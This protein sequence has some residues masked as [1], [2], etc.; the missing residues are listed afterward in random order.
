MGWLSVI[1]VLALFFLLIRNFK[2]EIFRRG[3]KLFSFLLLLV[4][5]LTMAAYYVDIEDY[6]SKDNILTETGASIV[7]VVKDN[8]KDYEIIDKGDIEMVVD[9][10]LDKADESIDKA[11]KRGK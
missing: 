7:K 10:S 6:F 4:L 9:K 8:F 1:L 3:L 11:K 2:H 5:I